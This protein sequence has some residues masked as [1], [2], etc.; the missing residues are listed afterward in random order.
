MHPLPRNAKSAILDQ[1]QMTALNRLGDI[2]LPE[3]GEHPSFSRV[4]CIQHVDLLLAH[5]PEED[6]KDLK[7]LLSAL[8]WL[9]GPVLRLVVWFA[10]RCGS[11]PEPLGTLSRKLDI[12]F[13][14]ILIGLYYSGKCGDEY[15][16]STPLEIMGFETSA[17]H[18]DGRITN[19]GARD[20]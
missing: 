17:V 19:T 5:A 16:G 8:A 11:W 2:L 10:L 20:V 1:N 12:A 15:A 13:R 18:L 7:G 14:S 4:G 9:P 6:M 3:N